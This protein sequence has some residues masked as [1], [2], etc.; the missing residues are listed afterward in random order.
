MQNETKYFQINM[1]SEGYDIPEKE[2]S[3]CDHLLKIR[4]G[5]AEEDDEDLMEFV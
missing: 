2:T 5:L 3:L 1:A 4:L